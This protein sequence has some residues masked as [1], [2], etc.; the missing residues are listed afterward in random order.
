MAIEI[1]EKKDWVLIGVPDRL[2]SFNYEIFKKDL[3]IVLEEK[4]SKRIALNVARSQFISLPSIKYLS[5]IAEGLQ[6]DGGRFALVGSTEKLKRQ[7]H[8]FASLESID[9][10]RSIAD[11]E[12]SFE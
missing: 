2:D 1:Q 11:W 7:F 10:F 5:S 9:V 4:E 3:A 6:S 8:I 12:K